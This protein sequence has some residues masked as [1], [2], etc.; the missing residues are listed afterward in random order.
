MTGVQTCALPI[1]VPP[2]LAAELCAF[3]AT[4][5]AA[6]LAGRLTHV[7]EPYRSYV[8]RDLGVDAGRLR[9]AGYPQA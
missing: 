4:D 7:K 5:E 9:R 6:P 8:E 1:W 3:M 2:T